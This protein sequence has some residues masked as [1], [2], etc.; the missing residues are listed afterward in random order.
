M[1]LWGR[2]CHLTWGQEPWLRHDLRQCRMTMVVPC[3]WLHRRAMLVCRRLEVFTPERPRR[4]TSRGR[5]P[6]R[7]DSS[8]LGVERQIEGQHI[9]ARL[10]QDAEL[11]ALGVLVYQR[12]HLLLRHT[13]R[14]SHAWHLKV[15]CRRRDVRV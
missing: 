7:L 3:A 10:A 13:P 9:D 1:H 12:P 2:R 11:P 5:G 15:G 14:L 4:C 6:C 8:S